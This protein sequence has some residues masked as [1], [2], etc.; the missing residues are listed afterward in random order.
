MLNTPN[1]LSIFRL[2][3]VPVFVMTYFSGI[4]H[5][6]VYAVCVYALATLTDFLDGYLARRF[7]LI[8]NL[9]KVLDPLGDKMFTFSV[10][11]C[12]CI[13]RIIPLWVVAIFFLKELMMG[14]GSLVI[15]RRVKAEI[16]PSNILGKTATV[17]FFLACVVLLLSDNIPRPAAVTMICLCLVVSLAAFISYVSSFL[18]IMKHR[19]PGK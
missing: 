16:P 5:A 13:D 4:A 11:V 19:N 9:G 18:I 17:L 15:H 8:T 12:I 6:E 1:I 7:K 14:L 3:L 2:C 10:L